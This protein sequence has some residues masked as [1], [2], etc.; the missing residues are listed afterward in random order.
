[1]NG[2]EAA[3]GIGGE[4]RFRALLDAAALVRGG[5]VDPVWLDDALVFLD[6][7]GE[8]PAVKCIDRATGRV[9]SDMPVAELTG[10]SVP[11]AACLRIAAGPGGPLLSVGERRYRLSLADGSARPLSPEEAAAVAARTPRVTRPGYPTT[12]PPEMECPSPDGAL[13]ATLRDGD[14]WLRSP[15]SGDERRMTFDGMR[16]PRWSTAGAA[17]SADARSL[18]LMRI[19]E[20]AVDRVPLPDW[21]GGTDSGRTWPYMRANGAIAVWRIHLIDIETGA[22]RPIGGGDERHFAFIQG[23]GADGRELRYARMERRS[24]S[25]E[26]LAFDIASGTT[27]LLLRE[28]AESFLYWPPTFIR[29][30]APVRFLSDGRFL[31]LTE[32]SGWNQLWLHDR[33][34]MPIRRLSEGD[35]PVTDIAAVHEPSGAVYFR[36]QPDRERPYDVH[37]FR[38]GIDDGAPHRLSDAD[39]V[40]SLSLAP[41]GAYHVDIHSSPDRPPRSELRDARG[42]LVAILSRADIGAIEAIGRIPPERL[43]LLADDGRTVLHGLLYK[44]YDFDP[45]RRYPVIE[46]IYAGPQ[47]IAVPHGFAI[48]PPEAFAQLGFVTLILDARGTPGRGKAFQ[49]VAVGRMGEYEIADHAGAIRHA[50][51][52]RP[53]MDLSRVGI[54][55]ISYGGYFTIRAM[56]QAPDLYRAGVALAPAELGPGIMGIPIECYEGLPGEYPERYARLRN[57]DKLDALRGELM[58]IS[59]ADDVNTPLEQTMAYA[60][61]LTK[62]GT[63]FDQLVIPNCNHVFVEADGRSRIAFV[64]RALMRHFERALKPAA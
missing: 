17:W 31:W 55:G 32:R 52:T 24:K 4:A 51:A 23:F 2:S 40:H 50:A 28:D 16:D 9:R 59:A 39:G 27:R 60:D 29:G 10:A 1:M 54:C 63:Q 64:Y 7:A 61:A 47:T 57:T 45:A 62:L 58:I 41:D 38:V 34:G 37:L 6:Q 53:W 13:V 36:G 46:Q 21:T 25:V 44:P 11:P 5:A 18:A 3:A 8:E 48:T 14:V 56:I 49:D 22:I 15:E 12:Q 20:R 26:L 19:D 33:D 43:R 42:G 30:G 35:W